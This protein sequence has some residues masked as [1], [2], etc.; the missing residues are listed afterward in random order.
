VKKSI[1]YSTGQELLPGE[2]KLKRS[3]FATVPATIKDV[4]RRADVSPSTVSRALNEPRKV[5][6]KT[7]ARIEKAVRELKFVPDPIASSLVSKRSKCIGLIIPNLGPFYSPLVSEIERIVRA[8][9]THLVVTTGNIRGDDIAH[10]AAFLRQRRCDAVIVNPGESSDREVMK[11]MKTEHNLVLIFRMLA[12]YQERCILVDN[13]EGARMATRYLIDCGHRRIAVITGSDTNHE[14][15]ER[16]AGFAEAMA[17]AGLAIDTK[18]VVQGNFEIA[19]GKRE[20][21]KLLSTGLPFTAVFCFNDEIA[22]GAISYLRSVGKNLPEEIS[23]IGFDDFIY[24]EQ[25]YPS[26]TTIQQPISE[27]GRIAAQRALALSQGREPPPSPS[28]LP[29]KLIVRA[30]VTPIRKN[31]A[32]DP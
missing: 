30:S 6:Q 31:A 3:S 27:M 29:P 1:R 8:E 20:V 11:M 21:A 16:Y 5:N 18:L 7:R 15:K 23:I 32:T 22:A 12:K 19:N 14:S 2:R 17:E 28:L 4:A 26:L 25:L 10:A 9:G 13:R 24:A